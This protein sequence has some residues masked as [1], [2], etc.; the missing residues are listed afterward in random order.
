MIAASLE[1]WNVFWGALKIL[2]KQVSLVRYEAQCYIY[3]CVCVSLWI[4][5]PLEKVLRTPPVIVPQS[6]F[7]RRYL[8]P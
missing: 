4:Q 5:T 6:H 8:D 7:L 2:L 1:P 3:I